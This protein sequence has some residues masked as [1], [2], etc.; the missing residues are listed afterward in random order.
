MFLSK[1]SLQS[2]LQRK[3]NFLVKERQDKCST[4]SFLI[5]ECSAHKGTSLLKHFLVSLAAF[6]AFSA[7]SEPAVVPSE[8][9]VQPEVA[10]VLAKKCSPD[11]LVLDRADWAALVEKMKAYAKELA[12]K[13]V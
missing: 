5:L 8:A 1:Y 13:T 9:F 6:T 2:Y 7:H 11:C 12:K 4:L 10:A 3:K